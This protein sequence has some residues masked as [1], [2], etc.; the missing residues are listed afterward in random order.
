ML[1]DG[2]ILCEGI[3]DTYPEGLNW[4]RIIFNENYFAVL[5][6]YGGNKFMHSDRPKKF[7]SDVW[8]EWKI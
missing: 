1:D 4:I 6:T 5:K 2:T 8:F 7:F 3:S